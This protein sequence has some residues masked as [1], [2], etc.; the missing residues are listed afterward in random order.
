MTCAV[1]VVTCDL[2]GRSHWV[3]LDSDC[4]IWTVD[5][6]FWILDSGLLCSRGCTV[7]LTRAIE[8]TVAVVVLLLLCAMSAENPV[9]LSSDIDSE[10]GTVESYD[11]CDQFTKQ[12]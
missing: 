7:Q 11:N 10:F 8:N 1:V 9:T 6:G 2:K 4:G 5:S 12:V 3:V